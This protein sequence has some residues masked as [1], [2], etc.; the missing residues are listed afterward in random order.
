MHSM[1]M[2]S[3]LLRVEATFGFNKS[4]TGKTQQQP[5]GGGDAAS[6]S[7]KKQAKASTTVTA[8]AVVCAE[9]EV[10]IRKK[11][12]DLTNII[13]VVTGGGQDCAV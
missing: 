5:G 1:G 4:A 8:A 2:R 9:K 12:V 13:D 10:A 7:N 11:N 3:T 6:P